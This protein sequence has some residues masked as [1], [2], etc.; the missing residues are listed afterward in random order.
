M[1]STLFRALLASAALGLG[2]TSAFATECI[3]PADAGGGWDFTCRQIGKILYDLKLVDQPVQVTNMAGAGGGLAFSHVVA[4]RGKDADLIVA[5]SSAT[6]TRLAQNAYGGATADQVRFVGAIGGDPGVI[7]VAK[8]SPYQTLTDLVEAIKADPGSV[9]FA[10]GSAAGGFDHLKPL[11]VLKAAGFTDVAKVKYI[12]MDG[13]AEAITQTIGGFTQA[14]TGDMSEIVGFIK[15]GDVRPLAVLTSERVPGFEDIPTAK[16]QGLNVEVVNWRGLYVP[17]GISD[18]AFNA[19]AEKLQKV[20]DSDE[21]KA[22]MASNGLAPF[23]KVGA[24]FQSWVDGV[25]AETTELSKEI[26]VIQ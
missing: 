7:V 16:E 4:E 9:A 14:M 26:G 21:W 17:K 13:G 22:V 5:A 23:T 15:S 3:A 8:D 24:D 6:T 10:G 18:D 2:A 19:W 11:M 20:A 25:V 12:G 1:K